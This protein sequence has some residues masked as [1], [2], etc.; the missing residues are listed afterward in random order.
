MKVLPQI[1]ATILVSYLTLALGLKVNTHQTSEEEDFQEIIKKHVK[2]TVLVCSTN[3]FL[4][5]LFL[6]QSFQ[7]E[8][9]N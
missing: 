5:P 8:A 6:E 7:H 2:R 3:N 4:L 1:V 9:I